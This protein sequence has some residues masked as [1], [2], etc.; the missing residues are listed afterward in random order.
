MM[1]KPLGFQT[2]GGILDNISKTRINHTIG[3]IRAVI[4][5]SDDR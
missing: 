3:R 1:L 5:I 2:R 4:F